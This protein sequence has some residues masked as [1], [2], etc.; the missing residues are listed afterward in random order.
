MNLFFPV[1]LTG[2]LSKLKQPHMA[3]PKFQILK[4]T[5]SVLTLFVLTF[6][7]FFQSHAQGDFGIGVQ[8]GSP[9]GI[10]AKIHNPNA[11]S[12][13]VLAAWD[14]FRESYFLNVSGLLEQ[15]IGRGET[16]FYY[17]AGGFI[18]GERIR[19]TIESGN[20]F[21]IGVSGTAGLSI[22]FGQVEVYGQINPRLSVIE[23]SFLAFGGGLGA[24][25]YF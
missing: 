16:N 3:K 20:V 17:G 2:F 22:F 11:V 13:E 10:T 25:Y 24:R 12:I 7:C 1:P 4:F 15:P 9:S 5:R 23:R 8:F 18:G 6:F 21:L 19:N 14:S